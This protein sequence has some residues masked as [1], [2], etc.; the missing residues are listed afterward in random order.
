MKDCAGFSLIELLVAMAIFAIAVS[1]ASMG[2]SSA[3]SASLTAVARQLHSDLQGIRADAMTRSSVPNSRGFGI[4]FTSGNAYELFEFNDTNTDYTWNNV[5]EESGVGKQTL[6]S[7]VSVTIGSTGNL[8]TGDIRL[9]DRHG[10][11]HRGNWSSASEVTYVL[12]DSGVA[13][14][15]CVVIDE[16]RIREGVWSGTSCTVQ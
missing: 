12:N 8:A 1:L 5:G 11:A 9:Y 4:R 3:K 15:R 2:W 7:S 16:V 14:A 6:P 13:Q 10:L